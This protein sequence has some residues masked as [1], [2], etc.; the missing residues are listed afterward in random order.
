MQLSCIILNGM[1]DLTLLILL[2]LLGGVVALIGGI[3]MLLVPRWSKVLLTYSVPFAAGVLL[4]ISLLGLIPEAL[5]MAGEGIFLIVLVSF[6]AAYLF[7]QFFFALH[8]HDHG[9]SSDTKPISKGS[10]WLVIVGDSIHNLIDGIAIGAAFLVSPA[11]AVVTAISSFLHEVPH[12][13]GDFGVLLKA[14]WR[15]RHIIIVNFLSA[16]LTVAGALLVYVLLPSNQ[17]VGY[18]MAISAGIFL[19]LGASDFLPHMHK[20]VSRIGMVTTLL[21]GVVLMAVIIQAVPHAHEGG[22][23]EAHEAHEDHEQEDGEYHQD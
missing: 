5:H 17:V 8:H 23:H 4:T 11:L 6:L 2:S 21:L 1:Q 10:A 15:K 16:L 14:G 19:Y 3:V 18:A 20:G 12:E 9:H 22:E 7:E 13:I